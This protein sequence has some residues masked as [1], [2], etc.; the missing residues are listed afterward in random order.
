M[1]DLD[2]MGAAQILK[3]ASRG[4]ISGQLK[5]RGVYICYVNVMW[6]GGMLLMQPKHFDIVCW[7]QDC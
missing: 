7:L 4:I 6:N 2:F 3:Y 5:F 1:I